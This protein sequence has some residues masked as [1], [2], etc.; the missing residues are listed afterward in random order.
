[1]LARSA[2][3][4]TPPLI[5]PPAAVQPNPATA[6]ACRTHSQG[7]HLQCPIC[8]HLRCEG[9]ARPQVDLLPGRGDLQGLQRRPAGR[10][11]RHGRAVAVQP[12]ALES[13][14]RWPCGHH[15]VALRLRS[16]EQEGVGAAGGC[17]AGRRSANLCH[18]DGYSV[19]TQVT[20]A[21]HRLIW[22]PSC[23]CSGHI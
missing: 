17:N 1:M 5:H 15:Q 4:H 12:G 19:R 18:F 3:T 16:V 22:L 21:L 9:Q 23:T 2:A 14:V 7:Q 8:P 13:R 6:G 11:P 20:I 10:G